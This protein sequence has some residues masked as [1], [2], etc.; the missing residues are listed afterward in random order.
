MTLA[1][2]GIIVIWIGSMS[3]CLLVVGLWNEWMRRGRNGR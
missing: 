1:T 2:V 3:F